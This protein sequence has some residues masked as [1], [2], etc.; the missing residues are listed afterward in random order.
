[1][2][3]ILN[4]PGSLSNKDNEEFKKVNIIVS[5]LTWEIEA[6]QNQVNLQKKMIEIDEKCINEL[7][8]ENKNLKKSQCNECL[9]CK[10]M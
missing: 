3:N 5:N 4:L 7:N 6:L 2:G 8:E 1:M 9:I 10:N